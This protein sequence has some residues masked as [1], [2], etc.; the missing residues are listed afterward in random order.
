MS[1]RGPPRKE[2]GEGV[3]GVAIGIVTEN[4]DPEGLGR[5]KLKFPWRDANDESHWA[6]IATPMAGDA[7]GTF[8]LPEVGDE[9]LVAFE[10][11]DVGHP[12][13]LGALWSKKAMPPADNADG[14]N[15]IR[16]VKTRSDHV[17]T[18]DD[19]ET[20]GKV[21]IETAAGH[22]IVLDDSSGSEKITIEDNAGQN[23]IEFDAVSGSLSISAGTSLTIEAPQIEISGDGN[24]KITANGALTLEGAII[25]LN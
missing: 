14:N 25:Q 17:L 1:F 5:V 11:G 2:A 9:V 22:S 13:V 24:V 18:F 23:T 15:D 19:D 12:Y 4:E 7:M 21:E 16:Q 3:T 8:F 6:R 10:K 20:D